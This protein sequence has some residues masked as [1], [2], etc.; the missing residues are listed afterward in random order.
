M[1]TLTVFLGEKDEIA[2]VANVLCEYELSPEQVLN[3]CSSFLGHSEGWIQLLL[4][5]A[6][7]RDSIALSKFGSFHK[8]SSVHYKAAH[9]GIINKRTYPA[10]SNN[11]YDYHKN[12]ILGKWMTET[13]DASVP[14]HPDF[15]EA[16][17]KILCMISL[18]NKDS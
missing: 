7:A 9:L 18:K 2:K 14:L 13:F 6:A 1:Q 5:N 12:T 8:I 17:F 11:S 4:A 15:I 10:G 16:I 3:E